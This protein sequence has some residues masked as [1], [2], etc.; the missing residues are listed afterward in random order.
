M[1]H[2]TAS[3][4]FSRPEIVREEVRERVKAAAEKLGYGGPDPKGRL[5]RAGKVN[6][7]GVAAAGAPLLFLRRSVRA[8]RHVRLSPRNATARAPAYR[9]CRPPTRTARL[10]H[11]ERAGRR[12]HRLLP[13]RTAR[14]LV[15]LAREREL[16]FVALD[17]GLEATRRLQP[18]RRRCGPARGPRRHLIE[19]GPSA[20]RDPVAADSR[21]N[22]T[23][24]QRW[25]GC[26]RD[27]FR[28]ARPDARLCRVSLPHMASPWKMFR[29]T[30]R[31]MTK[32]ATSAG[33]GTI[34]AS[35]TPPTAILA[36]S[37][38]MALAAARLADRARHFRSRRRIDRRL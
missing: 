1:S 9:W 38:R 12:F 30:R 23:G 10:E 3:N 19:L 22:T 15:E 4:V 21:T 16:P 26:G 7:I 36:M 34:F 27:L 13:A 8:R 2:G 14:E 33:W 28:D 31:K 29:S 17:F 25:E 5:L 18:W 37:D 35:G 11:Q 24:R 20:L 6:A 32:R